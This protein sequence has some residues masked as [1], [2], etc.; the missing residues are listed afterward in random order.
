MS[1]TFSFLL[2]QENLFFL[3]SVQCSASK[4]SHYVFFRD[5]DAGHFG[6][7]D[8]PEFP[9]AFEPRQITRMEAMKYA[10]EAYDL[11]VRYIGGCC[12]FEPYHMRAIAEELHKERGKLPEASKKSEFARDMFMAKK[13]AASNPKCYTNKYVKSLIIQNT[14]SQY[15]NSMIK[16]TM[17]YAL[18]K[19]I[20]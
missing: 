1:Q 7:V 18:H 9:Y 2:T 19:D 10:R 8:L 14:H 17:L 5:P 15:F 16:I 4:C 13:R 20:T 6:W 3:A 12:G 11:G